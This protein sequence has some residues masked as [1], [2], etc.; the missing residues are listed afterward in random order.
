MLE[1]KEVEFG[2]SAHPNFKN[3][4]TETKGK[5]FYLLLIS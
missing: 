5:Y 3:N 2:F 1:T 4:P